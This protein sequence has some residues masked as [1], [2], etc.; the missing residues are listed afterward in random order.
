MEGE[1]AS[2]GQ[3]AEATFALGRVRFLWDWSDVECDLRKQAADD[4]VIQSFVE[5]A[6]EFDRAATTPPGDNCHLERGGKR[7][8]V[9][10]AVAVPAQLCGR[11][12]PRVT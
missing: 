5:E 2:Q 4:S 12:S 11:L 6:L 10:V 1:V 8:G 3:E 7:G 9:W